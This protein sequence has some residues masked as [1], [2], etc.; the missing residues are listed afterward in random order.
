MYP[1]NCTIVQLQCPDGKQLRAQQDG[2]LWEWSPGHIWNFIQLLI[3][4][5]KLWWS[6]FLLF[7]RV[8]G[9]GLGVQRGEESRRPESE[10]NYRGVSTQEGHQGGH[11]KRRVPGHS[12]GAHD[13]IPLGSNQGSWSLHGLKDQLESGK[14]VRG[15]KDLNQ[16]GYT[17]LAA[18]KGFSRKGKQSS[19]FIALDDGRRGL[20]EQR[21]FIS[22][23]K[24]G[25]G[26]YNNGYW[27]Y[28]SRRGGRGGSGLEKGAPRFTSLR[29]GGSQG[30][31]SGRSREKSNVGNGLRWRTK[32]V[33][34]GGGG[35]TSLREGG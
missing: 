3:L 29:Q 31:R 20:P 17:S 5:V 21:G 1:L 8:P 2:L 18:Q 27:G 33:N 34:G 25:R 7:S 4:L 24:A 14:V 6:G 9:A 30:S 10:E 23:S 32:Y 15:Y 26:G 16:R 35:W 11:Y 13:Q 28:G 22:L 19:G 12:E